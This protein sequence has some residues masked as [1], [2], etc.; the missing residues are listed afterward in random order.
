MFLEIGFLVI[1]VLLLLFFSG[2]GGEKMQ[3]DFSPPSLILFFVQEVIE[4]RGLTAGRGSGYREKRSGQELQLPTA[5][6]P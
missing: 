3:I 4:N 1:K 5:S 2:I 6:Y